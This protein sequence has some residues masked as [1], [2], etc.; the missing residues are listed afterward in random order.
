MVGILIARSTGILL[1]SF[2]LVIGCAILGSV[3]H[4]TELF[5]EAMRIIGVTG[6]LGTGT[7]QA[8]DVFKQNKETPPA[9]PPAAQQTA[10]K[11][12]KA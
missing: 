11:W 9:A 1:L 5:K 10:S 2:A 7:Q 4:E 8:I 12:G 3:L 6:P